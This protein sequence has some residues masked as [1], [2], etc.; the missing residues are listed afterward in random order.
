MTR[1]FEDAAGRNTKTQ[2]RARQ[3]VIAPVQS[4]TPDSD[5]AREKNAGLPISSA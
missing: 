1:T 2:I 5:G 3:P 4:I